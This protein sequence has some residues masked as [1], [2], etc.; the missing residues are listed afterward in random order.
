M[1]NKSL[2]YIL[3]AVIFVV[4]LG[5]LLYPKIYSNEGDK[6]VPLIG[7]DVMVDEK[8]SAI[9]EEEKDMEGANVAIESEGAYVAYT[10][11]TFNQNK[12]KNRVLYFHADWCPICRPLDQAFQTRTNEIPT[13][14]VIFKTN[15]DTETSLK[16]KYGIT[17]QHTFVLVDEDGNEVK[18]WS[19]GD[20]DEVIEML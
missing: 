17:Y 5:V 14:Y 13:G 9:P 3:V 12:D 20:F 18:K 16:T 1:Q 7:N 6:A 2:L 4:G 11:D 19:G 8:D 15:Y 10:E